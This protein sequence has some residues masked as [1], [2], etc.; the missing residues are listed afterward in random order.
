VPIQAAT[1]ASGRADPA[2]PAEPGE[3]Q[4]RHYQ[5][6]EAGENEL[7]GAAEVPRQLAAVPVAESGV[8]PEV[9]IFE[10]CRQHQRAHFLWLPVFLRQAVADP[11]MSRL[12]VPF[13]LIN[14]QR[15]PSLKHG[16]RT[17][18]AIPRRMPRFT[19]RNAA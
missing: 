17:L 15:K 13:R 3:Q 12:L 1:T 9:M 5:R 10:F 16:N 8:P 18:P 7:G 11:L 2:G 6:A 4:Q 14:F 19:V